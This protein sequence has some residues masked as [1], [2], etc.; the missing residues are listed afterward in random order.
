MDET[1]LKV[2]IFFMRLLDWLLLIAVFSTGI[3]A[4]VYSPKNGEMIALASVAALFLVNK[5][6]SYTNTKIA[7]MRVNFKIEKQRIQREGR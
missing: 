2:R 7:Q 6:G 4:I 3:Y 5:L 1:G